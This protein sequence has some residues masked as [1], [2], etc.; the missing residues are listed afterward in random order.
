MSYAQLHY[1]SNTATP[2]QFT[3][4]K[5]AIQLFKTYNLEIQS[6]DWAPLF[7]IFLPTIQCK[8]PFCAFFQ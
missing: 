8:R 2:A 6:K 5:L 4:Y 7:I 3:L 1:Q